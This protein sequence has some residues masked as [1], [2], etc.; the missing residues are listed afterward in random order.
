[1]RFKDIEDIN[2]YNTILIIIDLQPK[3]LSAT[4]TPQEVL[5]N[6]LLLVRAANIFKIP[7]IITEQYPK[8]LGETSTVLLSHLTESSKRVEKIEF[9]CF[10]NEEFVSNLHSYTSS[11]PYLIICGVETHI[12]LFQTA[13]GAM[14][15]QFKPIIISDATSSRKHLDYESALK[16]YHS[17]DI[18]ILSTEMLIYLLLKKAGTAEFKA[19]LPYLK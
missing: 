3:I 15:R 17:L 8:G 1:M 13:L 2:S 12:C 19:L 5:A 10:G 16:A 14:K 9:N 4:Q 7:I 6:T 18:T 11:R